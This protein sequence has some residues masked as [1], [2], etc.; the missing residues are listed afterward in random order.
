MKVLILFIMFFSVGFSQAIEKFSEDFSTYVLKKS[1]E[2][3]ENLHKNAKLSLRAS[4]NDRLNQNNLLT[5]RNSRLSD[6]VSDRILSPREVLVLNTMEQAANDLVATNQNFNCANIALHNLSQ[7]INMNITECIDLDNALQNFFNAGAFTLSIPQGSQLQ[8]RA[9]DVRFDN[10]NDSSFLI[11]NIE[12]SI[13]KNIEFEK[14]IS[15][16]NDNQLLSLCTDITQNNQTYLNKTAIAQR[17]ISKIDALL[18]DPTSNG[19]VLSNAKN[20]CNSYIFGVLSDEITYNLPPTIEVD[21]V[22]NLESQ[23]QLAENMLDNLNDDLTE[24]QNN[25]LD[26]QNNPCSLTPSAPPCKNWQ[27]SIN[28]LFNEVSS[29]QDEIINLQEQIDDLNNRLEVAKG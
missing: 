3:V 1:K 19:V 20:L 21:E 5:T 27:S 2:Q 28:E 23:I 6:T 13:K 14:Q 26:A 29:I 4:T 8:L 18:L 16:M 17:A 24:A 9:A 15:F 25:L 12:R 10:L 11:K 7:R 22:A